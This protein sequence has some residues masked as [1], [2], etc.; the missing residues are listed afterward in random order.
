M[1]RLAGLIDG[2]MMLCVAGDF[3]VLIG[4]VEPGDEESAQRKIWM[5]NNEQGRAITGGDV[6]EERVG[7]RGH[8]LPE[9][10]PQN[11]L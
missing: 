8:V 4:V 2:Q 1:E 10:E 3:N 7:S 6:E 5:G 11:H 9:G